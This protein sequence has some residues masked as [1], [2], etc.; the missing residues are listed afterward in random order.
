MV[1]APM[2]LN[3]IPGEYVFYRRCT[4]AASSSQTTTAAAVSAPPPPLAP[5]DDGC[6]GTAITWESTPC[7]RPSDGGD[8]GGIHSTAAARESRSGSSSSGEAQGD[9]AVGPKL[10]KGMAD[11]TDIGIIIILQRGPFNLKPAGC[12]CSDLGV[13][14]L[15]VLAMDNVFGSCARGEDLAARSSIPGT[16]R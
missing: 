2:G 11:V 15:P 3:L 8:A 13:R 14:V 4:T 7:L 6:A 10:D 9:H 5:I 1:L 16:I 12:Y